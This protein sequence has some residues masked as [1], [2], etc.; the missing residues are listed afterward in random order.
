MGGPIT[1]IRRSCK[2]LGVRR[3]VKKRG[4][5]GPTEEQI[6]SATRIVAQK[7]RGKG[8]LVGEQLRREFISLAN[9][10]Q[11]RLAARYALDAIGIMSGSEKRKTVFGLFVD[12]AKTF[13][14]LRGNR[15]NI[16]LKNHLDSNINEINGILGRKANKFWKIYYGHLDRIQAREVEIELHSDSGIERSRIKMN[17]P[18]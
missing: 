4:E 14:E 12:S 6:D 3:K 5:R 9:Q 2:K 7:K 16:L 13:A 15:R 17:R 8:G 1:K 18:E 11:T 10:K